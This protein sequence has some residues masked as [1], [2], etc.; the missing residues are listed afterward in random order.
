[1]TG[2]DK[3]A[4]RKRAETDG[5]IPATF[6]TILSKVRFISIIWSIISYRLDSNSVKSL[7]GG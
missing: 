2:F 6:Q 7:L 1:M 3:T 5:K 4:E